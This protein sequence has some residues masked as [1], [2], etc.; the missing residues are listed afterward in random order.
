MGGKKN[1][2][3]GSKVKFVFLALSALIVG[4]GLGLGS[5]FWVVERRA[6]FDGVTVQGWTNNPLAGSTAADPYTRAAIARHGLLALKPTETVYF[7]RN[8]DQAGEPLSADCTYK[9]EG[10]ALPARWWSLTLYDQSGY[11]ARNTDAAFSLDATRISLDTT[12]RW[13]GE[14]GATRG[15]AANWLSTREAGAFSVLIRLYNPDPKAIANP[16]TIPFPTIVRTAC[17]TQPVAK[18]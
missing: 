13:A 12:G 6:G 4:L 17:S 16:E 3:R 15:A 11:L 2:A 8:R 7:S 5:A 10:A 14:I 18:G 1:T 9:I